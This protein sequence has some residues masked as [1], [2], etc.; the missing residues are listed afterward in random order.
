M[1]V[2]DSVVERIARA[3]LDAAEREPDAQKR[4][5][6]RM[7][8][9]GL[10]GF[11]RMS[12]PTPSRTRR[13]YRSARDDHDRREVAAGA[14][15]RSVRCCCAKWAGCSGVGGLAGRQI[16]ADSGTTASITTASTSATAWTSLRPAA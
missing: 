1:A 14:D 10:L 12:P 11:G 8:G 5:R 3:F 4:S 9:E 6:L 15:H 13:C 16:R 2:P 7:L